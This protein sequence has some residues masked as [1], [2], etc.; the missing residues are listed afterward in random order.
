LK[1][2]LRDGYFDIIEV[3]EAESQVVLYTLTVH[4]F[5]DAFQKW[6]KCWKQCIHAEEGYI[7]SDGGQ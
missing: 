2:K 3:I 5:Q 7:K 1:I 6:Q 4:D